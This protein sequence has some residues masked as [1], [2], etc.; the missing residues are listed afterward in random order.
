MLLAVT[1]IWGSSFLIIQNSLKL[2]GPFTL[3]AFSYGT[4]TLVLGLLSYKHLLRLKRS[5]VKAG[6]FIGLFLFTA[7]ALQTIGLKYTT[8]SKS[9]FITGLYVPLVSV[10]SFLLLRQKQTLGAIVGVVICLIGLIL[11]SVNNH[12]DFVFGLGEALTL[13]CAIAFALHIVC[14]S[15]FVPNAD[16][17]NLAIIQ[18]TL[19]SLLSILAM[20]FAGEP[21][22]LPPLSTW[23][24]L[25]YIGIVEVAFCIFT[26]NWVQQFVSSTRATLI[27]AL[28]P[29]WVALFGYFLAH[30]ILSF[31]AQIGCGFIFLG[32][33]AGEFR[34]SL[35]KKWVNTVSETLQK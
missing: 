5:E 15:R 17:I 34:F 3:L 11:L 4:G 16:A 7:Y 6:A 26:M 32:M 10:F 25:F 19:T 9:G 14:I 29:M 1:V 23:G 2:I 35:F 27:Y 24:A 22:A 28:E 21:F 12:F 18:I 8:T 20:M 30:E 31:P 13:G 33:I